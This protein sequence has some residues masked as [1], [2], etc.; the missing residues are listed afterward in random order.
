MK[1]HIAHVGLTLA[2]VALAAACTNTPKLTPAERLALYRA[3]AEEPVSGF[4]MLARNFNSWSAL[5]DQA[6]AVWPQPGQAYLLELG[7]PCLDLNFANAI[8][9]SNLM[10]RVSSGF[11]SVYVRG[12]GGTPSM[13]LPCRIDSIRPLNLAALREASNAAHTGADAI[14]RPAEQQQAQSQ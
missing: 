9:I 3:N 13:R 6:L 8:S 1:R 2:L 5:G 14:E 4:S 12:S 7:S 11:D 10:G